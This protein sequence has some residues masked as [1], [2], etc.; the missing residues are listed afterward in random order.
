MAGHVKRLSGSIGLFVGVAGVFFVARELSRHWDEVRA[1]AATADLGLLLVAF[2]VANLAM[3]TIGLGWRRCLGS[4]GVRRPYLDTLRRYYIGQLG[5]YV[6]GGIWPVVGRAEMARRG[7]VPGAVAYGSTVL[8]LGLTYLAAVLTALGAL[9]AGAGGGAAVTWQPVIALLPIG[10]LALHPRVVQSALQVLRRVSKRDLAV[11]VPPWRTSVSLLVQ[12][13][14]AWLAVGSATWIVALALGAEGAELRNV[15]FATA[16]S[17]VVGFL[18]VPVPGGIGV[19]EAVFVA[20]ATTLPSSG[21]AAAVAL[22]ARVL[23]ILVDTGGAGLTTALAATRRPRTTVGA[24]DGA[25]AGSAE[26][27]EILP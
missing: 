24:A 20:A 1:A 11:P 23:F 10:V 3:L 7:G 5:K 22:V 17:W 16:L 8:S 25:A 2:A 6:P 15:L 9:L 21:V 12:H 13:V 18:A 14:P 4:L 19:R 26:D 27:G